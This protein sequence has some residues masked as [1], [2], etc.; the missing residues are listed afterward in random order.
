MASE[1]NA[2]EAQAKIAE[3]VSALPWKIVC[4]RE[5]CP[6]VC[7]GCARPWAVLIAAKWQGSY[8]AFRRVV[9]RLEQKQGWGSCLTSFHHDDK[10]FSQGIVFG[11]DCYIT[12]DTLLAL[13]KQRGYYQIDILETQ[14]NLPLF[15]EALKIAE[16]RQ[17][18][19]RDYQI[20]ADLI[21]DN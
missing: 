11:Y 6:C 1:I 13:W 14:D 7:G 5:L 21:A 12:Q 3:A 16:E 4:L 2:T 10:V 8:S 9:K 20:V 19:L 18:E 17:F 15:D